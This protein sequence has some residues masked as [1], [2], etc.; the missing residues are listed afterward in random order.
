MADHNKQ[1]W[2]ATKCEDGRWVVNTEGDIITACEFLTEKNARMIA[3]L[4]ELLEA[5][6]AFNVG[7][8]DIV[9]ATS[10]HLIVRLPV[11]IITKAAAALQ[12]AQAN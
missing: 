4:P 10:E 6:E 7:P 12:K 8:D 1:K 11:A 9:G 2:I 3:A 5:V